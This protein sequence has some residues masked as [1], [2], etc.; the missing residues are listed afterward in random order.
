MIER[1]VATGGVCVNTGTI[2]QEAA[3][4]VGAPAEFWHAGADE[5]PR[6]NVFL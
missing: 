5:L 1:H 4:Q 3:D 2:S 6:C